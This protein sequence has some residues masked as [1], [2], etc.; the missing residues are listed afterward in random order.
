M[1]QSLTPYC[2]ER[3]FADLELARI[4]KTCCS[5]NLDIVTAEP[6]KV[7]PLE[8]LSAAFVARDPMNR[9]DGLTHFGLSHL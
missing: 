3:N 4:S 7:L 6:F 5:V 2:F 8:V 9:C 1:V